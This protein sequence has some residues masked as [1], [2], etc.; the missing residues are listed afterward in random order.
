M[1]A[2]TSI[3]TLWEEETTEE[4][5]KNC[6]KT[7]LARFLLGHVSRQMKK[8]LVLVLGLGQHQHLAVQ[9]L[10]VTEQHLQQRRLSLVV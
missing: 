4:K 2:E 5:K 3:L 6:Q 9:V 7:V 8:R 10:R 1:I